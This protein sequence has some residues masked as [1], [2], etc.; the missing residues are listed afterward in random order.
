MCQLST[1]IKTEELGNKMIE[2]FK[3]IKKWIWVYF[4]RK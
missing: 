1:E 4:I 2:V 3:D